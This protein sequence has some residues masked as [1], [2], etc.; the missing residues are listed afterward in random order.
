[1]T[2]T[3]TKR[4]HQARLDLRSAKWD[5]PKSHTF[6]FRLLLCPVPAAFDADV[7]AEA[8]A[9]DLEPL[10]GELLVDD[11]LFAFIV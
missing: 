11:E 8:D 7:D 2:H 3:H 9:D 4:T 1:M 5:E 10:I 6:L